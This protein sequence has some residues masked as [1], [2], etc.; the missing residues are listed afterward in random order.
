MKLKLHSLA[1]VKVG[2]TIFA[3]LV[4]FMFLLFAV[5]SE[6]NVFVP[7]YTLNLF[8]TDIKGVVAGSMVTLG[9]L[10]VGRVDNLDFASRDGTNGIVIRMSVRK[11]FQRSI[12]ESSEAVIKTIG[13]LGDKYIDISFGS[14]GSPI[15]ENG[16]LRQRSTFDLSEAA[17]SVQ[18]ALNRFTAILADMGEIT[19]GISSGRGTVGRLLTDTMLAADFTKSLRALSDITGAISEKRGSFGKLVYDGQLYAKLTQTAD[20]LRSLTDSVRIGAGSLGKMMKDDSLYAAVHAMAGSLN[21]IFVKAASDSSS[22]GNVLN[23]DQLYNELSAVLAELNG[24]IGEIKANPKKFFHI[25][26]F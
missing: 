7:T 21:T 1:D 2:M 10:K 8:V 14:R 23:S 15:E 16:F 22:I 19:H 6:Q 20:N 17:D 11:E 3:G 4:I 25:S 12:T 26:V 9:G 18:T 5:G 13:M 24:L